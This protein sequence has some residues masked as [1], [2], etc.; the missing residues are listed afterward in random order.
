MGQAKAR[1]DF[2]HRR[3]QAIAAG[4][5][6]RPYGL[7]RLQRPQPLMQAAISAALGPLT[8]AKRIAE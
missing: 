6:K 2:D 5:E 7:A 1:G 8:H 3:A 4:R